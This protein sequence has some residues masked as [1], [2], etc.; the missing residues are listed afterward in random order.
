MA[1][2]QQ[3]P[4]SSLDQ[5]QAM[6]NGVLEQIGRAFDSPAKRDPTRLV[7]SRNQ[8]HVVVAGFRNGFHDALDELES[9]LVTIHPSTAC[10]S[11]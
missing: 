9:E 10:D 4:P 2:T 5:L 7:Q 1:Q 11:G 8:L 3:A 6:L